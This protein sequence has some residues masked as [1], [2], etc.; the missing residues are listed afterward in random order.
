VGVPGVRAT[1]AKFC[2]SRPGAGLSVEVFW[3]EDGGWEAGQAET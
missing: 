3:H 1:T 2:R